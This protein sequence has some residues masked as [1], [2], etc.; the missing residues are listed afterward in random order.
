MDIHTNIPL[1]NYLTMKIGGPTRFMTDILN[2]DDVAKIVQNAR[3]QQL[4]TYIIGG[5]SNVIA[6]D[7][8]YEGIVVRNRIKGFE[9]LRED[10]N[11]AVL[12]LGAGEV[13]D[14]I[15]Q[16]TVEVGL[17]GIEAMSGIPGTCGAAPVQNIGAYGQELADTLVELDA[18]DTTTDQIVTL[19]NEQCQFSYRNSIFR[20]NA[21]GR[22]IIV[23]ITLELYK[24]LPTPPFYKT[25]QAYLDEQQ[26]TTYTPQ[27]VR[28]AVLAIR[29]SKLPD[30]KEKPNSGSF[31]KNAV[32]E[33]WLLDELLEE[34]PDMPHYPMD[35]KTYKI[36]SG[37]LIEQCKFKGALLHGMRVNPDNALVLINE[38]AAGYSDLA[39]ARETIR[40]AVRDTFRITIN[41][42]PLELQ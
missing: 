4:P 11:S 22:Y 34:Y 10:S 42:E 7:E 13:W 37:W 24:S 32:I 39:Q 25:L 21:F 35:S 15:V 9:V 8:Q 1:K 23:S 30:P 38:S 12:K 5:G 29:R 2:V 36:P 19:S 33:K 3:Q 20:T 17:T 31:F 28:E 6:H 40:N 26:I 18:Y 41:Q 14:E 16:K 27:T